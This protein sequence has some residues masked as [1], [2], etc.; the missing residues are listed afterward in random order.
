MKKQY[1]LITIALLK[2]SILQTFSIDQHPAD[3]IAKYGVPKGADG[4]AFPLM[5]KNLIF[6]LPII[7]EQH[8]ALESAGYQ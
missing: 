3:W 2:D 8:Y 7:K 4:S 6:A 5:R 1:W